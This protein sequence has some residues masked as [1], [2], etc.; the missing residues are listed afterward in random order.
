[1]TPLEGMWLANFIFIPII[2]FLMYKAKNDTKF[3]DLSSFY[4]FINRIKNKI[5]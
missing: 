5:Q 1:M 2:F 4:I 3:I